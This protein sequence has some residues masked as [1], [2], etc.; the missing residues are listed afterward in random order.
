[1]EPVRNIAVQFDGN[2]AVP[3]L[4]FENSC[5]RYEFTGGYRMVAPHLSSPTALLEN[6]KRKSLVELHAGSANQISHSPR[7]TPMFA[8]YLAHISF[9]NLEFEHSLSTVFDFGHRDM[10]WSIHQHFRN[11][12]D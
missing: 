11:L 3:S 10:V 2:F 7:R 12:L 6:F 9:S 8:D 4:R 1:M 5:Q